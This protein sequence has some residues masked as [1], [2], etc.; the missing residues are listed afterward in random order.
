M[1]NQEKFMD[2]AKLFD[3]PGQRVMATLPE[4][5]KLKEIVGVQRYE[6]FTTKITIRRGPTLYLCWV[7]T[8]EVMETLLRVKEEIKLTGK[9]YDR[10]EAWEL[11][12]SNSPYSLKKSLLRSRLRDEEELKAFKLRYEKE[13]NPIT[14]DFSGY[15]PSE[16]I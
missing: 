5:I 16:T 2:I 10:W 4:N 3:R 8:E 9:W 11:F 7:P 15:L 12:G 1:V 14:Q 13:V 6:D